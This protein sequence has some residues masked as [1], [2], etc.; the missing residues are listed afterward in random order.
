MSK[1]GE[2][3]IKNFFTKHGMTSKKVD[4]NIE[5]IKKLLK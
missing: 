2:P 1:G 5:R 3:K 4:E